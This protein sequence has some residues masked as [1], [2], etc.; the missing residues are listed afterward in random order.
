MRSLGWLSIRGRPYA[1]PA[2]I[3]YTTVD[4]VTFACLNFRKFLTLGLVATFRIRE[5]SFFYSGTIIIIIFARFL[6]SRICPPSRKL[7]PREIYR[8][9]SIYL[10]L[11]SLNLP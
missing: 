5:F 11:S 7:N 3:K 8:M 6:N 4:L 1:L 2:M 9:Y 10:T